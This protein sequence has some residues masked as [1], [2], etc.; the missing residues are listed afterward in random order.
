MQASPGHLGPH[1]HRHG[2]DSGA[3]LSVR[4]G[5]TD[6]HPVQEAGVQA[7]ETGL[8]CCHAESG[9]PAAAAHGWTGPTGLVSAA[10]ALAPGTDSHLIAGE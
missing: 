7:P 1:P 8:Q 5:R 9:P 4:G 2:G 10:P 3:A 6:G